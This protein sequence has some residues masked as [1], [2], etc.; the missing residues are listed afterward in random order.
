MSLSNNTLDHHIQLYQ[1]WLLIPSNKS[2]QLFIS[3]NMDYN[4]SWLPKTFHGRG[5]C[6][7]I[8][9]EQLPS[10]YMTDSSFFFCWFY[11]T[12]ER[13]SIHTSISNPIVLKNMIQVKSAY[14]FASSRWHRY[15]YAMFSCRWMSIS[16]A[17]SRGSSTPD[18]PSFQHTQQH[19]D[20]T[21]QQ[22]TTPQTIG[23][24]VN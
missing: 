7:P 24:A 17:V 5:V 1:W 20:I 11:V 15:S 2:I 8:C 6:L 23:K 16:S 4:V 13:G 10:H 18:V 22:F 14:T 3:S 9:K 12:D 19:S 21:K